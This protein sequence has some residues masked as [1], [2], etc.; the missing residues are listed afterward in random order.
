MNFKIL[1]KYKLQADLVVMN[2]LAVRPSKQRGVTIVEYALIA[3]AI[4]IAAVVFLPKIG[5]YVSTTFSR[6]CSGIAQGSGTC[7]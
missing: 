1:K 2:L 6:I 4:T 5:T 7:P 3:A